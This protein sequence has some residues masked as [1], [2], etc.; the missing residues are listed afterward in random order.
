MHRIIFIDFLRD[1]FFIFISN[2][3]SYLEIA[4]TD[5]GIGIAPE[6]ISKLF[7]PFIQI[8]SALNRQYAGTG[9]G[10]AL[11]KQIVEIHGGKVELTSDLGIG[12]CFKIELPCTPFSSAD[13]DDQWL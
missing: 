2:L 12:S 13:S 4:I 7:Q 8:D 3:K 10:L 11:V 9:L 6:N 1:H 5:T